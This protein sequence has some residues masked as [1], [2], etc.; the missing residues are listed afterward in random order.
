[1]AE[2]YPDN[3]LLA[4][5]F[6]GERRAFEEIYDRYYSVLVRFCFCLIGDQEDSKDVTIQVLTILFKKH[7]DFTSLQNIKAFLYITAR[8]MCFNQLK[9]TQRL[10][11]KYKRYFKNR[12]EDDQEVFIDQ[13]DTELFRLIQQSIQE[14]PPQCRKVIKLI[15]IDELKYKEVAEVLDTTIKNVENLRSYA[16]KKLRESL[17]RKDLLISAC[18]VLFTL[19]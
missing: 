8:N 10:T 17:C 15:Y 12:A 2:E 18:L 13:V 9:H 3:D 11:E 16:L 4:D 7:T 1:M 5:F 19:L 6:N 14:L